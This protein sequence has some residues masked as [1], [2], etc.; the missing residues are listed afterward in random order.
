[1]FL[2]SDAFGHLAIAVYNAYYHVVCC[3]GNRESHLM[4]IQM[5]SKVNLE[6]WNGFMN[7]TYNSNMH[8]PSST[9]NTDPHP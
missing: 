2:Y 9:K 4:A 6:F 7:E 3:Y 8:A 1:M 5:A